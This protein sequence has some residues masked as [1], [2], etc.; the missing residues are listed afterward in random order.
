MFNAGDIVVY[1]GHGLVKVVGMPKKRLSELQEGAVGEE[2]YYMLQS[3][4]TP[5]MAT[6]MLV[7]VEG[8]ERVLRYPVSPDEAKGIITLMSEE[9]ADLPE[10]P[11]ERMQ[12][13]ESIVDKND[14]RELASLVRDYRE[15]K[16]LNLD[17]VEI[18]RIKAVARNI[19]EEI[20]HALKIN[21]MTLKGK[22]SIRSS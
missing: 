3:A 11:K 2:I 21:R 19:A 12:I 18:T 10:D 14:V 22:F 16:L 1:R 15:C 6:K 4:R 13:L 17:R 5:L 7:K 8:A 20:C 9:S